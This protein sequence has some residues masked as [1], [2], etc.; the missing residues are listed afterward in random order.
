MVKIVRRKCF[1]PKRTHCVRP[2][3][4]R[5]VPL[6]LVIVRRFWLFTV[7][8]FKADPKTTYLSFLWWIGDELAVE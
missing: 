8:A 4:V 3:T 5:V 1:E 2:I 6:A 7:G